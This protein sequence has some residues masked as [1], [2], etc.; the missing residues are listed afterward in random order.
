MMDTIAGAFS[1]LKAAS[2]IT[3]GLIALKTDAAVSSKAVE[4]NRVIF[5]VQQ[6]LF[7]SQTE[8]TALQSRIRELE[9]E[10]MKLENWKNEQQRY[11]LKE[12]APGTLVYRL[13]PT[14]ENGEPVHDLCPHCYQ[15]GVKS[16]LQKNGVDRHHHSW[17]CPDCKT[18]FLG[19]RVVM[20]VNTTNLAGKSWAKDY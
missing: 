8:R 18:I 10:V 4:L 14:M 1:G 19:E 16:I 20:K 13:K 12:L 9:A 17:L 11:E 5:D 7:S 3:Q 15:K 2:E 6:Q